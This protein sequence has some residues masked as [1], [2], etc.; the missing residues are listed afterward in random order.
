MATKLEGRQNSGG[1]VAVV[2]RLFYVFLI[3]VINMRSQIESDVFDI[4][5]AQ[6]GDKIVNK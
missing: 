6:V 4:M 5:C 1:L 3:Q 2:D